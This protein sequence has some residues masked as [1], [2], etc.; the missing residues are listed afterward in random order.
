MGVP[1]LVGTDA[2]APG[3][4]PGWSAVLEIEE[5][6]G[7]GLSPF[8]ALSAATRTAGEFLAG[9]VAGASAIGTIE[10]GKV[11][12]LVLVEENP[13]VDVSTMREPVGVVLRGRWLP[14]AELESER[15]SGR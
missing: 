9:H 5:L 1:L 6:V 8:E 12:D 14:R 4:Y 13:L 7:A 11:A 2:S 15:G 3:L 10:L